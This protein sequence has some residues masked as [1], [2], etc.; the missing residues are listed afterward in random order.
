MSRRPT[1]EEYELF[2]RICKLRE[3]GVMKFMSKILREYYS[4][5]NVF[6]TKDYVYA[7]GTLPIGLV[8]HA[9]TVH[10]QLP[11]E[12]FYDSRKNVIWS[13]EGIGADDRAGIYAIIDIIRE[14]YRPTILI[15]NLEE[16]GGRGARQLVIDYPAPLS[17]VNF[18]LEMDRMGYNDMVFYSCDNPEFEQYLEPF[19]FKSDWGTF[20]DVEVIGPKW[21]VAFANLSI[22]YED[23][24]TK[25]ERLYFD[26]MFA[27]ISKVKDILNDELIE[28]HPFVYIEGSSY[29]WYYGSNF[30]KYGSSIYGYPTDDDDDG[31]VPIRLSTSDHGEICDFCGESLSDKNLV[32]IYDM[33]QWFHLCR[34]CA[35]ESTGICKKCGKRFFIQNDGDEICLNCRRLKV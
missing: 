1:N 27:T 12:I 21:G 33:G 24:H 31:W 7:K 22:G 3:S 34:T 25:A 13:P 6:A 32:N 29:G 11:S 16:V 8:A 30:S 23:E 17:K 26:W 14:G 5:E 28:E 9:D 15:C 35:D 20:S 4:E 10:T 2:T 18:L 19:G